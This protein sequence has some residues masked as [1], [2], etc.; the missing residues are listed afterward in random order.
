MKCILCNEDIRGEVINGVA[1]VYGH[2]PAPLS[3]EGQ[4]CDEC[5][6]EKVIPARIKA[7]CK[8]YKEYD[9]NG[10]NPLKGFL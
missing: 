1:K 8:I 3:R 7:V 9:K 5:N 10:T 4:C 2:N 6:M